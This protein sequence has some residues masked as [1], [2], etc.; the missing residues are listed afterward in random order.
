MRTVKIKELT[1]L[2]EKLAPLLEEQRRLGREAGEMIAMGFEDAILSGN[3][4]SDVLKNLAQD[5]MRLIFRNVITA[6]L[7]AGIGNFINGGLGFLAEGG[8][9]RAGSPYIVGE[10]DRSCSCLAL[11]A[12]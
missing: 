1:M 2:Y 5:L 10:K 9:A 11:A 4:L 3:K 7:A 6:P 8:P 12:L